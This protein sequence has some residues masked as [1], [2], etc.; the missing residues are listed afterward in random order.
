MGLMVRNMGEDQP[1]AQN[2]TITKLVR[3]K[4]K[5]LPRRTCDE[6]VF[7]LAFGVQGGVNL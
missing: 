2:F 3:K 7:F 5:N 4:K 1:I 6:T